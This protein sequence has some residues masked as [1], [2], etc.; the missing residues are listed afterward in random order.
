VRAAIERRTIRLEP[1]SDDDLAWLL[2]IGITS[3]PA[4]TG[5]EVIE[6]ARAAD[7]FVAGIIRRTTTRERLGYVLAFPPMDMDAWELVIAVPE[8]KNRD[9]FSALY[10]I[11]AMAFY[12]FEHRNVQ[13]IGCRIRDDNGASSAIARRVGQ[14]PIE[15][16]T[17]AGHVQRIY[18]MDR[19]QWSERRARIER[20]G[21]GFVSR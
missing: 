20:R 14:T 1:P 3:F 10:A 6:R 13:A 16:R 2:E 18:R 15:E 12:M 7:L 5:R 19:A 9:G 8:A 21:P 17:D 4:G 11:D